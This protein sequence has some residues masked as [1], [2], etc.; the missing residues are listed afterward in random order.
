MKRRD[1]PRTGLAATASGVMASR[2]GRG[3]SNLLQY[4]CPPDGTPPPLQATPSP[5]SRAFAGPLQVM[6]VKQPI[7]GNLNP[8]PDPAAH[9]LWAQY[10]P[11]KIYTIF[12][13]EFQWKYHPDPPYNAGSWGWGFDG[14]T[15]GPTYQ[16]RYG[17]PILVRRFNSLPTV[18]PS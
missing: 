17:E 5:V 10:P 13:Q 9:Q 8:P 7:T 14:I 3:Q 2:S 11:K 1:L 16:A 12:E 15:P 18:G 6:P 4:L